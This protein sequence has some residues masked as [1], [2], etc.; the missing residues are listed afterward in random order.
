MNLH[1]LEVIHFFSKTK[2]ADCYLDV[3]RLGTRKVRPHLSDLCMSLKASI[4][5]QKVIRK[6][7][8]SLIANKIEYRN[9][10]I[11]LQ[12]YIFRPHME[13][14]MELYSVETAA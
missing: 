14:F 12:L 1:K 5:V 4:Q 13:L 6:D 9:N 3:D 2:R 7:I 11:L 10:N 8:L